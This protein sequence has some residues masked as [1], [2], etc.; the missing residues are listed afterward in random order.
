[1][2][3]LKQTWAHLDLD[4]RTNHGVPRDQLLQ[5]IR[6]LEDSGEVKVFASGV[7]QVFR[8]V[9]LPASINELARAETTR[10]KEREA[11]EMGRLNQVVQFITTTTE[12]QS[13]MLM[14]HF[15]EVPAKD[16]VCTCESCKGGSKK[17]PTAAMS[18]RGKMSSVPP[19]AWAVIA[20]AVASG[21]L[22]SDDPRLLTRVAI[23]TK[24][25]RITK[26]RLANHA[27]F[28]SLQTCSFE[29][30]LACCEKLCGRKDSDL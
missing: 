6:Q 3:V 1:M 9:N 7:L 21:E 20:N 25:P 5:G 29:S 14:R 19:A 8:I 17:G 23:G 15:G 4:Q 27:A 2:V 28:G 11:L 26:L 12:C 22:P 16:W 18:Q 13:L 30:V 10:F 24:S